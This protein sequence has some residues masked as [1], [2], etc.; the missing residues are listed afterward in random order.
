MI[1]FCIIWIAIRDLSKP[2]LDLFRGI[3][4]LYIGIHDSR[5]SLPHLSRVIL[6]TMTIHLISK[7]CEGRLNQSNLQ[8]GEV[9]IKRFYLSREMDLCSL[10]LSS[11]NPCIFGKDVTY[12]PQSIYST[13]YERFPLFL[14]PLDKPVVSLC[15]EKI[16]SYDH[17]ISSRWIL[18]D[19]CHL[20]YI[21][22]CSSLKPCRP[23]HFS[24]L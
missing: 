20:A 17:F 16:P 11:Q 2:W 5:C 15:L 9:L 13:L 12:G 8:L 23:D 18:R 22:S 7:L 24:L 1:F 10:T 6:Q 3:L 19:P 14:C 21:Y 4:A